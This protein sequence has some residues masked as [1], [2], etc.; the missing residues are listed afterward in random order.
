MG[1]PGRTGTVSSGGHKHWLKGVIIF[2][3]DPMNAKDATREILIKVITRIV[4]S[5]VPEP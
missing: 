5:T 1:A 4:P 2:R 3:I